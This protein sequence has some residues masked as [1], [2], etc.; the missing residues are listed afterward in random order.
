MQRL[1][2]LIDSI[3][4]SN[5][6]LRDRI[7]SLE[8]SHDPAFGI[9]A[10]Q[11]HRARSTLIAK[12]FKDVLRKCG[13]HRRAENRQVSLCSLSSPQQESLAMSAFSDLSLGDVSRISL[14]CL[15][16][17]ST[18][19]SNGYHYWF[20]KVNLEPTIR[21][22]AQ[23]YPL[24][25]RMDG[26]G[27]QHAFMHPRKPPPIPSSRK[28]AER[29]TFL[30]PISQQVHIASKPTTDGSSVRGDTAMVASV[31]DNQ[32]D[33]EPK[34][35]FRVRCHIGNPNPLTQNINGMPFHKYDPGDVR[36]PMERLKCSYG[37]LQ[38]SRCSMY[39]RMRDQSGWPGSWTL[40]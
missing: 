21:Y 35:L 28:T 26:N 39:L 13:V 22:L 40:R 17:W 36:L 9:R 8:S 27:S 11:S 10:M 32:K 20:G 31:S 34:V 7:D 38:G 16:V 37:H 3:L 5:R 23:H 29:I 33:D 15:P 6:D 19:L 30:V 12:R 2:N 25:L 1:E 4:E 24:G 18:D 14:L